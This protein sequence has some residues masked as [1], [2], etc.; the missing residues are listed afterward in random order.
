MVSFYSIL[1]I[2]S[3]ALCMGDSS[4]I[5]HLNLDTK[6][7]WIHSGHC[8]LSGVKYLL[9][10]EATLAMESVVEGEPVLICLLMGDKSDH[11]NSFNHSC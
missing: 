6:R 10:L 3:M 7:C 4:P 1:A 11:G 5:L 2:T 8:D 9:L